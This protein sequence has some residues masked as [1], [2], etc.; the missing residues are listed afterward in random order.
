[1]KNHLKGKHLAEYH[2][3]FE[4]SSETSQSSLMDFTVLAVKKLPSNSSLVTKLTN[5]V[6]EFITQDLR[7]VSVVDGVGFLHLMELAEPPIKVI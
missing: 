4:M 6:V 2:L 3:M 1:M 7:P 5:G